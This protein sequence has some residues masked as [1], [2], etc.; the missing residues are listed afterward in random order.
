MIIGI[1]GLI[2]SGKD[3]V[4]QYLVDSRDYTRISMANVLKDATAVLFGWDRGMLEGKT[5]EARIIREQPDPFWSKKLGKDFSPRQALQFLGTDLFRN[6]LHKDIWAMAAERQMH[7]HTNVVISDI[8]FSNEIDMIRRNGGQIWHVQRG[9]YPEWWDC[10]I[11]TN[12]NARAGCWG[13]SLP[14]RANLMEI[15]YPHVH[16]SEW[17][18]V[19]TEFDL[20]LANDDSLAVLYT[21]VENHMKNT[22]NELDGQTIGD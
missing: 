14:R 1:C 3:T 21:K 6:H 10:A 18:W 16:N 19:G 22:E 11:E 4:A 7:G 5:P 15:K 13:A 12:K 2:G 20:H 9:A 8:R 17:A